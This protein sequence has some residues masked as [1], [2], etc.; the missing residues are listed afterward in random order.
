MSEHFAI[1]LAIWIVV[2]LCLACYLNDN[3]MTPTDRCCRYFI[4]SLIGA[5]LIAVMIVLIAADLIS[6]WGDD[7]EEACL[8]L[9][10]T[11]KGRAR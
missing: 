11:L 7:A 6:T 3:T 8:R 2:G 5:P 9:Q 1:G 4:C 10:K